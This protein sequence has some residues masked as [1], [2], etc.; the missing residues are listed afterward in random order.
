[1]SKPYLIA[2]QTLKNTDYINCVIGFDIYLNK[3]NFLYKDRYY[4]QKSL[5]V[6]HA[7]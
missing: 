2:M 1:M 3:S 6:N 4:N 7:I 5:Q